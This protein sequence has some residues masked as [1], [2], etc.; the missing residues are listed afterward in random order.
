MNMALIPICCDV[1]NTRTDMKCPDCGKPLC[2]SLTC[3]DLHQ[4]TEGGS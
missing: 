1:C 4:C 3:Y 2:E